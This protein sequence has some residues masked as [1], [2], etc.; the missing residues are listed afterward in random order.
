MGNDDDD[1][2]DVIYCDIAAENRVS[3]TRRDVH[4]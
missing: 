4:Y 3:R 2:D 1:D